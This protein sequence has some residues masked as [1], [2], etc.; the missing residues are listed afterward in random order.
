MRFSP[1]YPVTTSAEFPK[2]GAQLK[3][4]QSS[5]LSILQ[6]GNSVRKFLSHEGNKTVAL[7]DPNQ[8]WILM[9]FTNPLE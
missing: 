7:R 3:G 1:R 6:E 8:A 2:L 5:S 9:F 4:S